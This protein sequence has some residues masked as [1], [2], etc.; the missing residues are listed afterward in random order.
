[1]NSAAPDTDDTHSIA[2]AL[3]GLTEWLQA[4]PLRYVIEWVIGIDH[5]RYLL[6]PWDERL[7]S[8]AFCHTLAGAL[9][10][11]QCAGSDMPFSM[12]E[13]RFAPLS[14]G[15]PRL[16]ALIPSEVVAELIAVARRHGCRSRQITPALGVVWDSLPARVKNDTGMLALVEG[17][18]MLRVAYN[19][20]QIISLSVQP[21]SNERKPAIPAGVTYLFPSRDMTLSTSGKLAPAL[22]PDDDPRFAYALCGVF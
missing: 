21:Y 8:E 10:A 22:A 14:F 4:H 16:A 5:V 3:T 11:Q 1:M 19:G 7:S 20:G 9:F 12:Y 13:L 2:A 6:L 17:Q 15:Q 18:R